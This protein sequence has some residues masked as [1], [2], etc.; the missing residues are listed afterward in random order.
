MQWNVKKN[1]CL[2]PVHDGLK[3]CF[4]VPIARFGDYGVLRSLP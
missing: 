2:A 4:C 3:A 1:M